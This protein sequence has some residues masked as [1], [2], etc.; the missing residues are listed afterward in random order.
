MRSSAYDAG[1]RIRTGANQHRW[2]NRDILPHDVQKVRVH[3]PNQRDPTAKE[4]VRSAALTRKVVIAIAPRHFQSILNL[5]R[6]LP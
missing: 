6:R 5:A 2:P 1:L 3:W 4:P